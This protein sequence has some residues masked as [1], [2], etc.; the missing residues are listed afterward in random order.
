MII[1]RLIGPPAVFTV[2]ESVN[3]PT[4]AAAGPYSTQAEAQARANQLNGVAAKTNPLTSPVTNPLTGVNAI[5]DL[6]HRL[7]ESS[8]WIR[9]GEFVAGGMLL[10]VGAKA[11]FPGTVNTITNAAKTAGKAGVFL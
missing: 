6:A 8:T 5:G 7:T 1:N 9:V 2:K 11:F 10:F 3:K 4:G